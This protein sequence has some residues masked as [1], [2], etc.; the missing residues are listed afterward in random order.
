MCTS[1]AAAGH[2][3]VGLQP[4]ADRGSRRSQ[5]TVVLKHMFSPAELLEEPSLK[6]DLETDTLAECTKLGPVEK[7]GRRQAPA[8][9]LREDLDVSAGIKTHCGMLLPAGDAA[10]RH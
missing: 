5:V 7:V 6:D 9:G 3:H 8:C 4:A 1:I 2:P 10:A